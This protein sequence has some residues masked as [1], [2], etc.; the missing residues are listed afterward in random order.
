MRSASQQEKKKLKEREN[1]KID[2]ATILFIGAILHALFS[3]FF[4]HDI[5]RVFLKNIQYTIYIF[6]YRV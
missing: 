1:R 4:C 2:Y 5:L 6:I 3:V